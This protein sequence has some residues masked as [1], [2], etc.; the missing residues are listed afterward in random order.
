MSSTNI[1]IVIAFRRSARSSVTVAMRSRTS[2]RTVPV[3]SGLTPRPA[4]ARV[5]G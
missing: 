5:R 4:P 1:G 3:S 2:T